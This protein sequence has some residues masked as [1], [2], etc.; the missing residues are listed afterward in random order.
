MEIPDR[1]Y[2]ALYGTH[3]SDSAGR[4]GWRDAVVGR[5]HEYGINAF[6]PTDRKGW[7]P[8]TEKNGDEQQ[9]E[10]NR[11]VARQHR[12]LLGAACVIHHLLGSVRGDPTTSHAA[13][14]ELAFLMGTQIPTFFVIEPKIDGRNY[15][16]AVAK[17]HPHLHRCSDV[18]QA[19]TRAIEYM[20]TAHGA[21]AAPL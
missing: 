11:L 19:T 10:I 20:R 4:G 16:W 2:V 9:E 3:D 12:A 15:L 6:D 5:L 18:E 13:R 17:L 8:I 14:A 7:D 1:P 21:P